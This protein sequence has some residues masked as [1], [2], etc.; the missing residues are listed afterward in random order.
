[1][2]TA[3]V[4]VHPVLG[5]EWLPPFLPA[6]EPKSPHLERVK[7]AASGHVPRV[8]PYVSGIDWVARAVVD[9][10]YIRYSYADVRTL[11][12]VGLIA[13]HENACRYCYGTRRALLRLQGL[14][15]ATIEQLESDLVHAEASPETRAV[16]EFVRALA[17]SNPRPARKEAAA[18]EARGMRPEAVAEIAAECANWCFG[19]RVATFVAAPVD[20]EVE[21]LPDSLLVRLLRPIVRLKVSFARKMTAPPAEMPP[22]DAPFGPVLEP[23]RR[24]HLGVY[25]ADSLRGAFASPVLPQRAKALVFGVV[26]RSLACQGCEG[27]ARRLLEGGG[28]PSAAVDEALDN[29]ASPALDSLEAKVVAY[30]RDTVRFRPVDVQR[31]TRALAD[32]IGP[33]PALEAASVAALANGIVRL[34]MLQS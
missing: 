21:A 5:V 8:L 11:S 16:L 6:Y 14:S 18:L 3:E 23:I 12:L 9:S 33:L 26:A 29:L 20:Q 2:A 30:A 17:R 27:E 7:Q 34:A 32:A 10:F 22:V 19:N 4:P 31:S 25:F 13:S 24:A 1:M 15:V 28:L